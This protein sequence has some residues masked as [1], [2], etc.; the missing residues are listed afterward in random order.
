MITQELT[1]FTNKVSSD[2]TKITQA[3]TASQENMAKLKENTISQA[4]T[5]AQ[6][7]TSPTTTIDSR[8]LQSKL[9]NKLL[10]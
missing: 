2:I 4:L 10:I 8:N 5:K 1:N 7:V 9:Y 6:D 3:P